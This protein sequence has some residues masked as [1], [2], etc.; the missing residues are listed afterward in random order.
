MSAGPAS[1]PYCGRAVTVE[2]KTVTEAR[3]KVKPGDALSVVLPEPVAAEP[4]PETMAL[5]IVYEDKDLIVIDKPAGLV[6]HPG[7]G[8]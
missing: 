4:Q 7:A 3:H 2:G 1:G 6:V 8:Q 5:N